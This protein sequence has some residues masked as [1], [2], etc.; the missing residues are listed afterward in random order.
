M[1]TLADGGQVTERSYHFLLDWNET[2]K[3]EH[4]KTHFSKHRLCDLTL[5]E[6][7]ILWEYATGNEM[8]LNLK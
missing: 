2:D 3:K 1:K 8:N 4:I 6:Y 7:K 5:A